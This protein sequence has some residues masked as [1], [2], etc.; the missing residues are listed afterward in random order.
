[1][2]FVGLLSSNQQSEHRGGDTPNLIKSLQERS[3]F[4]KMYELALSYQ[5]MVESCDSGLYKQ[6][7]YLPINLK[8]NS[9]KYFLL[10]PLGV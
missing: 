10:I 2:G 3:I 6:L 9:F 4:L 5:Q 8:L 7:S 1:M